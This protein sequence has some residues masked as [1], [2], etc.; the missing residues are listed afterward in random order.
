M[1]CPH[2]TDVS[3]CARCAEAPELT[4]TVAPTL[5]HDSASE[6]PA[7]ATTQPDA[8]HVSRIGRFVIIA[9]VGQGGMGVVYSAY[10]PALNRRVA[11]KVL[12]AP[13]GDSRAQGD[14]AR[15]AREAQAM[16]QLSHPNVV[17]V[18]DV[19]RL[20]DSLF[21][22][23]E[24]I[25]GATLHQ[26]LEETPRTWREVLSVMLA[27]GRGLEAAH[28][29]GLIHRD[30]K[31]TN[32]LVGLDGRVRV[33]DFGLARSVRSEPA[34][35][36]V[37][38]TTPSS[39][40]L[41]TPLTL[42][43]AVMGTP[44][45]MA[46]EQYARQDTSPATDQFAFCVSLY[47]ALYGAR[48]FEGNDLVTL[49]RTT[50]EGAVPAPPPGSMVPAWVFPIIA[51]GLS[52]D[53]GARHPSMRALLDA[54]ERDPSARR[55]RLALTGAAA[56]LTLGV[57]AGLWAWPQVRASACHRDTDRLGAV[58]NDEARRNTERAFRATALPYAGAAWDFT[59]AT[60]DTFT[61]AWL[62]ERHAACDQ[63]LRTGEHTE[64]QLDL[65]TRCLERR[66]VE[67]QTLALRFQ[68]ADAD[69]VTL[70]ATA[71]AR[72]TPVAQ[73]TNLQSL[74]ARAQLPDAAQGA[75]DEVEQ[76][77]A[78][79]RML[80]ALGRF[81]EARARVTAAV[82]STRGLGD[83]QTLALALFELGALE[84]QANAFVPSRAPLEE[85]L[86]LALA[87]GDQRTALH[88]ISLLA[89]L[90]GWRLNQAQASFALVTVGRGLVP[91]VGDPALEALL[92]EGEGDARWSRDESAA[93]LAAYRRALPLFERAQGPLGIDVA[94]MHSSIGWLLMETGKLREA[95]E[96]LE[97][98]RRI[99][100]ALLGADHPELAPT[101]NE[102]GRLAELLD[103]LAGAEAA[104]RR[105][106]ALRRST[107][108]LAASALARAD[109]NL[110]R[111]LIARGLLDEADQ[112]LTRCEAVLATD[113]ADGTRKGMVS[114][115][116][117]RAQLLRARG[118][119]AG[120]F[121]T[122]TRA[123]AMCDR[124]GESWFG[125][126]SLRVIATAQ[127]ALGKPADALNSLDLALKRHED[128][129]ETTSPEFASLL[130]ERAA[131]LLTRGTPE[132][133]N[134]AA[135]RALAAAV[136]IDGSSHLLS[137]AQLN[138]A[139]ARWR[140]GKK[141]EAVEAAQA[142]LALATKERHD[143]L[144]REATTFLAGHQ[145]P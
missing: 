54:L 65:R 120:A 73:C 36:P 87:G 10:D 89:S 131:V 76:Q 85:A 45:Y 108:G 98:S 26:W 86:T 57:A 29:A 49:E 2:G 12:R 69:V 59:R 56:L 71:V 125:A 121:A 126:V 23:M 119:A 11:I 97:R 102:L 72:L 63:T 110:A 51:K 124:L 80:V 40:S 8:P 75:V 5:R 55:R 144:A 32:V 60:L 106:R 21:I 130:S 43:G 13:P 114:A 39:L 61:T 1:S 115:Q 42:G 123:L 101:W 64:R 104:L 37:S 139:Q 47:E 4:A 93:A 107:Q 95:R 143:D 83:T 15:L 22:A 145:P 92:E 58:W 127:L 142:A 128:L 30:F 25:E 103:D 118:D 109:L 66:R 41:D 48:P 84:R 9:A 141:P 138:A 35:E 96:A 140:S 7:T 122:A 46:L 3:T 105:A 94:R 28:G 81:D 78:E 90:L 133:A 62:A 111:V 31:P 82:T 6:V 112:L 19:G 136:A 132:Q 18:Y 68:A 24:F 70:A 79:G 38:R 134:L 50:R 67:L 74:E 91:R 52:P 88:A 14:T 34:R 16:A 129:K 77:L 33:T 135:E 100:E 20:G 17:P 137:R 53:P 27:A 99:R 117:S 44:G 116:L 113:P